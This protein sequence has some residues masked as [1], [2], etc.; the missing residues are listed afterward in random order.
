MNPSAQ[1]LEYRR[2]WTPPKGLGHSAPRPVRLTRE[3]IAVLVMGGLLLAG[4]AAAGIGLGGMA[5]RQ[6]GEGRMLREQGVE[7]RGVITRL[8]RTRGDDPELRVY[9]RFASPDGTH[10]GHANA[11]RRLWDELRE[12]S[13]LPIRYLPSNPAVSVPSGW[14]RN[15]LPMLAV[16]ACAASL[17]LAGVLVIWRVRREVYLLSEGRAAPAVV[18]RLRKVHHHHHHQQGTVVYYEFLLLSGAAAEG[19]YGPLRRPPAVGSTL[20][21]VYDPD[22]LRRSACYPLRLVRPDD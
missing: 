12:G 17:V 10:T 8:R 5:T 7:V 18:T 19:K 1:L 6:A 2:I 11:P 15:V 16:V 13:E 20:S 14:D 3:G 4:A 22:N 9:Y 21:V